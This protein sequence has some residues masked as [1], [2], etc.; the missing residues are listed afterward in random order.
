M[1]NGED[2]SEAKRSQDLIET[3]APPRARRQPA[4]GG[5]LRGVVEGLIADPADAKGVTDLAGD[6][7]VDPDAPMLP[8]DD[9]SELISPDEIPTERPP[10]TDPVE[11][12]ERLVEGVLAPPAEK[13]VKKNG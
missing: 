3:V 7:D 9:V 6:A 13:N 2:D 8:D 10:W 4:T 1:Q 11:S 12:Q 5:A